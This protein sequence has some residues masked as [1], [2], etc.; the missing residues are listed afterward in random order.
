MIHPANS[1][2]ADAFRRFVKNVQRWCRLTGYGRSTFYEWTDEVHSVPVHAL[3]PTYRAIGKIEFLAEVLQL[4]EHGLQLVHAP[5]AQGVADIR[6]E[7]SDITE[8]LG[9]V[10]TKVRAMLADGKRSPDERRA[11]LAELEHLAEQVEEA[12]QAVIDDAVPMRR[13]T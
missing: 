12:K 6:D 11:V 9:R 13:V 2:V 1:F 10:S 8:A 3:M 5:R 7:V 4:S